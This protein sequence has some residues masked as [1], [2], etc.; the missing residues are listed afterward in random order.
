MPRKIDLTDCICTICSTSDVE[1][2]DFHFVAASYSRFL[3]SAGLVRKTVP[4][5]GTLQSKSLTLSP[6]L[7]KRVYGPGKNGSLIYI[8]KI[9]SVPRVKCEVVRSVQ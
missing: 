1:P 9:L 2:G 3:G 4:M 7:Q 8:F 6:V 5:S